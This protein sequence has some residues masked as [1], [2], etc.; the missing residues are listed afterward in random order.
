MVA[1]A[2]QAAASAGHSTIVTLLLENKPP[3]LVDTTGG[4]HGSALRAAVHSGSGDTVWALLEED[5]D[6]NMKT[7]GVSSLLEKAATMG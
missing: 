2:L 4:H 6:P 1:N 5:A 7:K 3:V